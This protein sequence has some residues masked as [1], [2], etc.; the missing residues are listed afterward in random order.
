MTA[1][2][3]AQTIT[4]AGVYDIPADVYHRDPVEGGSLSS[5]GARKILQSPAK[6]RWERDHG[7]APKKAWDIGHAA[8]KVVLGAGPELVLF[9]GTGKNPEAWQRDDDIAAVAA[10][11]AEG[12][13]PLKPSDW[14]TVHAMADAIRRHPLAARL[15]EPA[16]GE[17]EQTLVWLDEPTGVWRRAMLDWR[18]GRV[19]VD[20]KSA[21]SASRAAFTKAVG[22]F[23]YHQQDPYY[24]DGVAALG[25]ADDPAFLFVVQEKDPPYLVAVYDIDD[26][27]LR[28]GRERN[29]RALEM[30]RD[31]TESG[32]WPGYSNDIETIALP[33][34]V[35]RQDEGAY[36]D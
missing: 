15:F 24:R 1:V 11:R 28:I 3:E 20:Y 7:R 31:C 33:S 17:P 21:A 26:E 19:I 16:G 30:Y 9:P 32:L 14:D 29:R 23:G 5:S 8:H 27:D 22:N 4:L 34:W 6:F 25:L 36:L 10:L 13:V 2:L 18:R 35:R 12:K